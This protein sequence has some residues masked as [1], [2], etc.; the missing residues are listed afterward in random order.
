MSAVRKAIAQALT[1]VLAWGGAVVVS[2]YDPITASEWIVLAGVG[3]G[4]FLVW[5]LPNEPEV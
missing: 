5:Y 1:G 4:S 2:S 3:V